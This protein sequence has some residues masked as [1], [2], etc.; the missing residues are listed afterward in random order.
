MCPTSQ[1]SPSSYKAMSRPDFP[2]RDPTRVNLLPF[3]SLTK[4]ELVDCDLSTSAWIG[5]HN[6]QAIEILKCSGCLE[7]LHH[8]LSPF[9]HLLS[10]PGR[11]SYTSLASSCEIHLLTVSILERNPFMI[12]EE[13]RFFLA[14]VFFC[15]WWDQFMNVIQYKPISPYINLAAR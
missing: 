6:V 9:S 3:F 1:T 15:Q 4:L 12:F 14:Y 10:M 11:Q 2:F 13:W 8:L 7:E 5:L